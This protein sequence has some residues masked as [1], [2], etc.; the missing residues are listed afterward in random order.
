MLRPGE[1][2]VIDAPSSLRYLRLRTERRLR[3]RQPFDLE[4]RALTRLAPLLKGYV[5]WS[6]HAMRPSAV[7]SLLDDVQL[8]RRRSV[9]ECGA[10]VSTIY[11]ARLL[12]TVD[13]HLWSLEHDADWAAVVNDWLQAEGLAHRVTLILA[14]LQGRDP[15]AQATGWYGKEYL[16]GALPDRSIDLL[17]VDGPPAYMPGAGL[18]RYPAVPY[19][20]SRLSQSWTVVLDDI[21]RPGERNVATRWA[22]LL[23][24]T[25]DWRLE[26]GIAVATAGT[27]VVT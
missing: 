18:A 19:F 20:K 14:P 7:V 16:D 22:R 27:R 21:Q 4:A 6:P 5:A 9:V 23:G 25:F 24:T 2:R 12:D 17:I 3:R 8:N 13:G 26:S 1:G 10:G 11:L 15:G